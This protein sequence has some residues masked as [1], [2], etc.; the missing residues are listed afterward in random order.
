[1]LKRR[2]IILAE[3]TLSDEYH[4]KTA[5]GVLRYSQDDVLAVVDSQLAGRDITTIIPGL[6][7]S[8][9]IV[10]SVSEVMHLG[11]TS[12][13]VGIASVGGKLPDALRPEIVAGI[14][15]GLEIVN[16]LH[17]LLR[18]D[19]EFVARAAR[20]GSR[21]WDVREPDMPLR[22]FTGVAYRVPQMVVLTVGTD[23]SI[24]KMS[25][26]LE[27]VKASAQ[28]GV[29]A[30]FVATGQTGIMIAGKGIAIDRVIGDYLC[31]AAEQLVL[32]VDPAAEV[33]LV[34]GQGAIFHPAYAP[35]TYGL[36]YGST[37]DALLLCHR[38]G[39]TTI[40]GFGTAIPPLREVI[41]AHERI[42]KPLKP[43]ACIAVALNTSHLDEPEA[44]RAIES[45][46]AETGLPV[47]DVVRFGGARL[48]K[49][50]EAAAGARKLATR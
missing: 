49:V 9:P 41:E 25:V 28:S 2:Y 22:V 24:G 37:P 38:A 16:G 13:L 42:V 30:E 11:A 6:Q 19:P 39:Q 35:V 26:S 29:R 18:A 47:D 23:C 12:L 40:T 48:W 32:D 20:S 15:A 14:D 4:G 31:G 5:Q 21:L 46:A 50:V 10:A 1:M 3:G 33:V 27:L 45:T 34:E 43:A 36:L 7:R 17:D 8:V 44:R